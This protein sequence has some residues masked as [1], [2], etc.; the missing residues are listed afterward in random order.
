MSANDFFNAM[1]DAYTK[2]NLHGHKTYEDA[3]KALDK[4]IK[5]YIESSNL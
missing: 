2:G 1:Y 3:M 4:D 5:D